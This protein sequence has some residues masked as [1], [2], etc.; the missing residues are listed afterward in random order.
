[1]TGRSARGRQIGQKP[2]MVSAL[3][4]TVPADLQGTGLSGKMLAAMRDNGNHPGFNDLAAPVRPNRRHLVPDM[5]IQEY[6]ALAR[7]DGLPQDPWL[8]VHARGGGR[9]VATCKRAMVIP[10]R[11]PSG[12]PGR[13]C[14][15]V[16]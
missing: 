9:I 6:A 5:P 1:V 4:I 2:D 11:Q 15:S 12:V 8:R 3:E 13:P 10:V 16:R 14:R 7:E